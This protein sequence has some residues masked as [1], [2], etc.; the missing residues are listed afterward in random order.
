MLPKENNKKNHPPKNKYIFIGNY[1]LNNDDND[2]RSKIE[3][4]SSRLKVIEDALSPSVIIKAK[5]IMSVIMGDIN[6]MNKFNKIY[7]NWIKYMSNTANSNDI[8]YN[9]NSLFWQLDEYIFNKYFL[10]LKDKYS[11]I[12]EFVNVQQN[13]T[14]SEN[15]LKLI[16]EIFLKDRNEHYKIL[17]PHQK[18]YISTQI[19]KNRVFLMYIEKELYHICKNYVTTNNNSN[20][21]QFSSEKLHPALCLNNSVIGNTELDT[22]KMEKDNINNDTF[23]FPLDRDKRQIIIKN[24]KPL[25]N[26]L[27]DVDILDK[28][29]STLYKYNPA[30]FN[31]SLIVFHAML[32]IK[33]DIINQT[34]TYDPSSPHDELFVKEYINYTPSALYG[35]PMIPPLTLSNKQ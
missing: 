29:N 30:L 2:L 34:S 24:T 9:I 6:C 5:P 32:H 8:S 25:Y 4:L 16:Q 13:N 22:F 12:F 1:T 14:Y 10:T 26:T 21:I 28:L 23:N 20:D 11:Y 19:L 18:E 27:V 35:H 7:D 3:L 33:K 17:Y 31:L 15:Q